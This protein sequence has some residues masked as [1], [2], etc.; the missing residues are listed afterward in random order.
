MML[1]RVMEVRFPTIFS[2]LSTNRACACRS[3][4]AALSTR[5]LRSIRRLPDNRHVRV[6]SLA[7]GLEN[8]RVTELG[9]AYCLTGGERIV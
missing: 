8:M 7:G 1:P 6:R 4:E 2:D 5:C 9:R 3:R